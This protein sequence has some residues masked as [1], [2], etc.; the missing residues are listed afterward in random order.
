MPGT[1]VVGSNTSSRLKMPLR[2]LHNKVMSGF[3]ALRKARA[4]MASSNS[5]QKGPSRPQG[6]FT[7]PPTPEK[8]LMS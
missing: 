7:A 1:L 5:R 6:G 2:F 3:Q 8:S 4:P